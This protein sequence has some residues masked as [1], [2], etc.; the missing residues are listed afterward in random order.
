MRTP[1]RGDDKR[2]VRPSPD[3]EVLTEKT[4]GE[5]VF[6]ELRNPRNRIPGC[7]QCW[8]LNKLSHLMTF[9]IIAGKQKPQWSDQQT[10]DLT[11]GHRR[12]DSHAP[13]NSEI[14]S[15]DI[16][17]VSVEIVDHRMLD[18]I[19]MRLRCETNRF[20]VSTEEGFGDLAVRL[21]RLSD[22]SSHLGLVALR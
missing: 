1:V 13:P 4:D 6:T 7:A 21:A 3:D 8:A 9:P 20:G 15:S 12:H 17:G 11:I 16:G 10:T 5:H 19:K 22:D 2:S 18:R 14:R